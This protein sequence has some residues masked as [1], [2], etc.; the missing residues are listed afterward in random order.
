[1]PYTG[2]SDPALPPKVQNAPEQQRRIFVAAFNNSF[3]RCEEQGGEDCESRAFAIAYNAM[4]HEAEKNLQLEKSD[5]LELK[6]DMELKMQ[7]FKVYQQPDGRLRF[8]GWYSNAYQDRD[9]E[10][11]PTKAIE[12]DVERMNSQADY[13]ELWFYHMQGAKMGK[14][15]AAAMIGRFAVVTGL[16]DETEDAKALAEFATSQGYRMSHGFWYDAMQFVD[17]AYNSYQTFEVS[18]LPANAAANP[19]TA[20]IALDKEEKNMKAFEISDGQKAALVAA[21]GSEEAAEKVIQ[22]TM[23]ATKD[24]DV[25]TN[26]NYKQAAEDKPKDE[27]EGNES[28]AEEQKPDM[29]KMMEQ[30]D[31]RLSRLEE[32]IATMAEGDDEEEKA[33]DGIVTTLRDA[34]IGMAEQVSELKGTFETFKAGR[35]SV[36]F[37]TILEDYMSGGKSSIPEGDARQKDIWGM[38]DT[39]GGIVEGL[40]FAPKD[41]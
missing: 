5:G 8:V 31:Q 9:G 28:K 34:L 2:I 37:K 20:F 38:E 39:I 22:A 19:L 17:G 16:V 15:D 7:G 35:D 40:G 14:A 25:A 11:F 10:W 41:K 1:M 24:A 12:Q 32:K 4:N 6:S 27:T 3:A 33:Y 18:V 26:A 23:Q 13:P 36:Q 29:E 21:F 30:F